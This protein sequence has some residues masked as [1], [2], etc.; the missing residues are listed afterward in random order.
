MELAAT[1]PPAFK[2]AHG[3]KGALKD[4]ARLV[5]PHEVIDRPK[6]YFPVPQAQIHLRPLSRHGARRAG[7]AGGARARAVPAGL[8]RHPLRRPGLPHHPAARIGLWQVALL[9]MWLQSH[10]V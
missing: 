8:S 3:G 2:L 6:G 4:A 10:S 5:V 7:L 9:E 1:I